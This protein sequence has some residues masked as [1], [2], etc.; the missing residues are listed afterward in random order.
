MGCPWMVN[1][2]RLGVR[3]GESCGEPSRQAQ[4]HIGNKR[5]KPFA[6]GACGSKP[7][8]LD[9]GR[10]W[11]AAVECLD[12]DAGRPLVLD[13]LGVLETMPGALDLSALG[14]LVSAIK[15]AR[16]AILVVQERALPFWRGCLG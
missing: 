9:A 8:K 5:I 12:G 2:K 15:G 7:W 1:D 11:E 6:E 10:F 16:D 3:R 14:I 4:L 13:E